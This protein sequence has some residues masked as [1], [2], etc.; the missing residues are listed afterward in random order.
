MIVALPAATPVTT[1]VT[2]F[3]VATKLLLLLQLPPGVPLLLNVAVEPAHMVAEPL[4]EPALAWGLMVILEDEE[5]PPQV[6]LTV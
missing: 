1:P 6:L 2:E 3:T 5:E 4:T